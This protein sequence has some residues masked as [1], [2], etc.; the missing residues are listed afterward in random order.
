MIKHIR[1]QNLGHAEH[2]WLSSRFHFS[3][4]DYYN[5]KR[6]GFGKL[7]VINDDVI[8]AGYGFDAHP[9][10]NMEIITYVRNGEVTHQDSQGNKGI[11]KAGEVQ[12]MSA[13]SG[14]VHSEYNLGSEPLTLYQ[15]WI[16][17]ELNNVKPRWQ[18]QVFPTSPTQE[19]LSLLVSGYET[20]QHD[21]Q[22]LSIYQKTRIFAGVMK[23]G[24][25]LQHKLTEQ[26]YVLASKGEFVIRDESGAEVTLVK[27]DGAEITA[28][29]TIIFEA[30]KD[31]ELLLIDTL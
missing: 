28:A 19:K 12:V 1:Y 27:G 11:T 16:E 14:I 3:F 5:P 7:R 31:C 21:Q 22:V 4:A 9:H 6:M 25:C 20:D 17:T 18:T 30:I 10:R 23:K 8:K 15:I 13:G 2:G 26:A 24:A 29:K